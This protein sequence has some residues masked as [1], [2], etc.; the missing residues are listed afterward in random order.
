[1]RSTLS[2]MLCLSLALAGCKA[3]EVADK[4]DISKDLKERGTTELMEEVAKDEY[5]FSD[6]AGIT[7]NQ[8]QM[9]L[10]VREKEKAIALVARKE[11]EQKAK[12]SADQI[13]KSYESAGGRISAAFK[14]IAM[15]KLAGLA[16]TAAGQLGP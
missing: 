2:L 11:M 8:I 4:A 16:G 9:Y 3:K 5:N 10:K 13:A 14:T 15:P 6:D 7:E 12:K 1:M